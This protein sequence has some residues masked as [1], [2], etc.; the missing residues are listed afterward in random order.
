MPAVIDL[1]ESLRIVLGVIGDSLL[2][3]HQDLSVKLKEKYLE[4]FP[5]VRDLTSV[6]A[7]QVRVC[8]RR[9]LHHFKA[10]EIVDRL[11]SYSN[12]ASTFCTSSGHWKKLRR[13]LR[14]PLQKAPL[15][16]R[17]IGQCS[18]PFLYV[19]W[20]TRSAGAH[21]SSIQRL[22]EKASDRGECGLVIC[23]SKPFQRLLKYPLLFQNLLYHTDASTHEY[24]SAESMAIAIDGLVRS[25]EDEKVSEE[26]RDRARD[27]WARIEGV[28]EKA[29]VPSP[30]PTKMLF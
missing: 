17:R 28:N 7:E 18:R 23:L 12:T 4:Q 11:G 6:W 25:I 19:S 10:H 29:S 15:C 8:R 14:M 24:E 3:G 16:R 5:L 30:Y 20:F 2:R 21:L 9:A 13:S 1:P 26:E 27:A 22:E